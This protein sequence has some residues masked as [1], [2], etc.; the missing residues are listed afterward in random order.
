MAEQFEKTEVTKPENETVSEAVAQKRLDRVAE[1]V[2][3]KSSR[4]EQKYDTDHQI[5]SK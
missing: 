4:T 1:E 2:A 5:F 3:E